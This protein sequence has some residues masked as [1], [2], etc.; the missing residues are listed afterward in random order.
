[1]CYSLGFKVILTFLDAYSFTYIKK[2]IVA[3]Q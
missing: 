2:V 1:M 3:Y